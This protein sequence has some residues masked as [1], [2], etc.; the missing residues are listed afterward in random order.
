MIKEI[1]AIHVSSTL[2]GG[3]LRYRV[4]GGKA[5]NYYFTTEELAKLLIE[6]GLIG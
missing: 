6:N 4:N 5:N 3:S 2:T 1:D